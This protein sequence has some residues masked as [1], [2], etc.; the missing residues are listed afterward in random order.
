MHKLAGLNW[1]SAF[2]IYSGILLATTCL[3]NANEK[4]FF[5]THF[6]CSWIGFFLKKYLLACAN[7]IEKQTI[8]GR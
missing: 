1:F 3:T 5:Q 2:A 7:W 8:N 6:I 4:V